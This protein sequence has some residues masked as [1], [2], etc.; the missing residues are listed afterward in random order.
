MKDS[1]ETLKISLLKKIA[2]PIIFSIVVFSVFLFS[3]EM[4]LRTTHMFG[5]RLSW[6]I[7]DPLIGY[8]YEPGGEYW[9][10]KENDHP[11]TGK[12]NNY[13]WRDDDWSL[14]KPPKTYRIAVLGDSII[15]ALQVESDAAFLSLTEQMLNQNHELKVDLMNFGRSGFTQTEELLVLKNDVEQFAPDMVILFFLP[16]NDIR[17]VNRK[18]STDNNR[19]F[20]TV[21]E[22]GELQ[23]DRSFAETR[24]YKISSFFNRLTVHSALIN[25]IKERYKAYAQQTNADIQNV[26]VTKDAIQSSPVSDGYLSLCTIKPN[27]SYLENY[28]LNKL[29]IKAMSD[30]CK[31]RGIRFMLV[32]TNISTYVYTP[33]KTFNPIFFEEDLG[34]Y[35]S[36]L[37]IDYM[38]LQSIFAEYFAN[39]GQFLDFSKGY[40]HWNY[41]GHKIVAETLVNKLNDII[42]LQG[43]EKIE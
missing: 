15:E 4:I 6:V 26:A 3:L 1:S 17:D 32:T 16:S 18:T 12:F 2:L 5:A 8:R 29:L 42:Y 33:P 21:S 20:Y 35:A 25:L 27:I 38:G 22:N 7:P 19:P 30:Y 40:G 31:K 13:G 43:K 23:L 39:T 9:S 14:E 24:S 34:E 41:L 36:L 37:D 28:S 11:I 10:L